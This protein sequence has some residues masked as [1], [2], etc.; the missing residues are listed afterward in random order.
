MTALLILFVNPIKA[1][2]IKIVITNKVTNKT[3]KKKDELDNSN[4][5]FLFFYNIVSR[6]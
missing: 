6:N 4:K 5:R 3:E 1:A 2:I